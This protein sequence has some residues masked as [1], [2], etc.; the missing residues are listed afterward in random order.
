MRKMMQFYKSNK[1]DHYS[2]KNNS[3]A[4]NIKE[5]EI[6]LVQ[7]T[8]TVENLQH[9]L[10]HDIKAAKV[11]R[12]W[13]AYCRLRRLGAIIMRDPKKIIRVYKVLKNEGIAGLVKESKSINSR[14]VI[15]ANVNF[16]YQNWFKKNFPKVRDLAAQREK[17]KRFTLRPKISIIT[18][19]Y[20]TPEKFLKE[21][22]ESVIDQS[23]D[24]WEL[25]L[26]DDASENQRVRDIIKLY[27]SKDKRIKYKFREK[28]GHISEASN[29]ALGLATGD[30]IGLLDHDDVGV[31][32]EIFG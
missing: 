8:R 32:M 30:F 28:N 5:L 24:N 11:F 29:D 14:S 17:S 6:E 23:Y 19:T 10:E 7:L 31:I 4:R 3:G 21:C 2:G 12:I 16:Q 13:Q 9:I 22:I 20:N 18:P 1:R 26:V 15:E 27:T 25:C